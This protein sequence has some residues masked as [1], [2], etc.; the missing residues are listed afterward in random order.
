MNFYTSIADTYEAIFPLNPEQVNFITAA[1]QAS[2]NLN[3]LDVGCGT[4]KLAQALAHQGHRVIGIDL[5]ENMVNRAVTENKHDAVSYFVLNMLELDARFQSQ[6]F[7]AVIC[8][9]NTLVHLPNLASVE[10][11]IES[12]YKVLKPGGRLLIQ[13]INYDRILNQLIEG[14]PTIDNAEIEFVRKYEYLEKQ[15]RIDFRTQLTIKASGQII[16]NSQIL[17]PIKKDE[18][19]G[20]IKKSGFVNITCFGGFN[21]QVWD[22]SAQ[23]LIVEATKKNLQELGS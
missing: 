17:L 20:I 14:L 19:I 1:T 7:D 12:A 15:Y 21:L 8:F 4:G 3:L 16:E 9:G 13:I 22:E 6:S 18:L 23:P 2:G 5:N 10:K 11:F